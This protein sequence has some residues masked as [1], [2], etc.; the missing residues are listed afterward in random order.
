M[1]NQRQALEEIDEILRNDRLRAVGKLDS[2]MEVLSSVE[3]EAEWGPEE[4]EPED[5]GEEEEGG[6]E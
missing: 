1:P 6:E 5:E 4:I 2:I 3:L